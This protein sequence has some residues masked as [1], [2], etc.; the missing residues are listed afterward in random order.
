MV[1]N[2]EL[3]AY[4]SGERSKS[5]KGKH[6]RSKPQIHLLPDLFYAG[7]AAIP[8]V[9]TT[10]DSSSSAV[11]SLMAPGVPIG[12]RIGNAAW[13]AREGAVQNAVPIAELAVLGIAFKWAGKKLG[14]NRVGTMGV[15]L[16]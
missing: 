3:K 8:F 9:T 4:K 7:A 5:N 14:L 13:A 2:K 16:A 11:D 6:R 12:E 15:K 1:E 10:P